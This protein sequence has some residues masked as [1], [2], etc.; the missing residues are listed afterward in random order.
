MYSYTL[1]CPLAIAIF[2]L[3]LCKLR[4]VNSIRVRI[5]CSTYYTRR[6]ASSYSSCRLH[7][8]HGQ[9]YAYAIQKYLFFSKHISTPVE[10]HIHLCYIDQFASGLIQI[11]VLP[12]TWQ[13]RIVPI[14]QI[15]SWIEPS[16][17]GLINNSASK[18]SPVYRA[19]TMIYTSTSQV[20]LQ[21]SLLY[22]LVANYRPL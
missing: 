21:L 16:R 6:D 19:Q 13:A 1:F 15:D 22:F 4:M 8:T 3:N 17:G 7:S 12:A 2:R 5:C 10:L 18:K 20:Q 14:S 11:K 9:R